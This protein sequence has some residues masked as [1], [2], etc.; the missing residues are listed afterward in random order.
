MGAHA[1]LFDRTV[2]RLDELKAENAALRE[3]LKECVVSF[4]NPSNH[5][6]CD[7][8]YEISVCAKC[9]I[10]LAQ[11]QL[12]K[13][14]TR[15][16]ALLGEKVEPVKSCDACFLKDTPH[17]AE[18]HTPSSYEIDVSKCWQPKP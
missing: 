13:A 17:C 2:K 9:G 18:H 8:C 3:C 1:D 10:T 16:K 14:L 12:D 6:V 7:A 5:G 15:A 4:E 11:E